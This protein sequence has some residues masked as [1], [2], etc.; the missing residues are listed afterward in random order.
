VGADAVRVRELV[1]K[2]LNNCRSFWTSPDL[3]PFFDPRQA[4]IFV[5]DPAK[6]ACVCEADGQGIVRRT[7]SRRLPAVLGFP[8]DL[9]RLVR[10]D[11]RDVHSVN[12]PRMLELS[13][14]DDAIYWTL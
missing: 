1:H 9:P 14:Y 6:A 3:E 13:L 11:D 7:I 12:K 10:E 8:Q 2:R 5:T 4:T